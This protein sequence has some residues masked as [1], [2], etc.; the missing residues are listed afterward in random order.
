MLQEC[1]IQSLDDPRLASYR[2]MRRQFDHFEQEIFV[3]EGVKVLHRLLETSIPVISALMPPAY[4]AQF[5]AQFERRKEQITVFT[6]PKEVL[7]QLTGFHLYHGVLALAKVP[8]PS[9]LEQILA[10]PSRPHLLVALDGVNNS[11]NIGGVIRNA[12]AFGVAGLLVSHT[13]APPYIRRAVRSSMGNVFKLPY[14][15][16]EDLGRTLGDLRQR[17]IRVIAA[18]P[19]TDKLTIAD[20]DL[21]TDCC[22]VF[23]SEGNGISAPVLASCNEAVAIPMLQ[24]TDSLNIATASAVFLYEAQRQ[25]RGRK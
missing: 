4:L 2:T 9:T 17:G 12:V 24:G 7:E 11:E 16:A 21:T 18:H 19:H 20:T 3:A 23:G 15:I 6:A 14:L 8:A 5:A 25:S 1:A 22:L 13:S 10:A